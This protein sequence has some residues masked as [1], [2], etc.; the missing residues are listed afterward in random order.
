MAD[1]LEA[2]VL[3]AKRSKE[4]LEALLTEYRPFVLS[5]VLSVCPAGGDDALQTGFI[6]FT[7]AVNTYSEEKGAFLSLAKTIIKRRV[8]DLIRKEASV[9]EDALIDDQQ[10]ENSNIVQAASTQVYRINQ[11]NEERREEILLLTAELKKWS[12]SVSQ[13]SKASPRHEST[14]N[15]CKTVIYE[16]INNKEL[17][18][19]FKNEKRL[20]VSQLTRKTGIKRKLIEDHRRYI[21]AAIIIHSGD[22]PYMREYIKLN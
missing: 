14:K 11:E 19:E 6:A 21:V 8:V 5:A 1:T 17:L 10:D 15:A 7:Q 4:E 22:F 12:I 20:P 16:M 3:L 13:L 9:K 18:A 2:R